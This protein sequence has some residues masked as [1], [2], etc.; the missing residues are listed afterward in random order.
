MI[1][2]E[3]RQQLE[4]SFIKHLDYAINE[5]VQRD[6]S[7]NDI[8]T[9]TETV[10]LFLKFEDIK[11]YVL[12]TLYDK[13]VATFDIVRPGDKAPNSSYRKILRVALEVG[14]DILIDS[15]ETFLAKDKEPEA[16]LILIEEQVRLG[17]STNNSEKIFISL[18]GIHKYD[19]DITNRFLDILGRGPEYLTHNFLHKNL[20]GP[21][22]RYIKLLGADNPEALDKVV[23]P[24]LDFSFSDTNQYIG[25]VTEIVTTTD[26]YSHCL[27]DNNNL[28]LNVFSNLILSNNEAPISLIKNV[29]Q[30]ISKYKPTELEKFEHAFLE[31]ARAEIIVDYAIQVPT[32]N[33]RK[34]LRQLIKMREDVREEENL[35]EFIKHFPEYR[36]L[37][38]ML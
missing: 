9:F 24:I 28:S 17:K 2:F 12:T 32:S 3:E 4:I 20:L 14:D 10:K 7:E 29:C 38:P 22:R 23:R 21:L 15:L 26:K 27:I 16:F 35:V 11:Q 1:S 6:F 18:H 37:L 19:L 13:V 5:L 25:I 31:S 33:K 34:V 8:V 30:Y 36:S